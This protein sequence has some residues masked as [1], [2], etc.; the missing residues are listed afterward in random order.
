MNNLKYFISI[1]ILFLFA[2]LGITLTLSGNNYTC[3]SLLAVLFFFPVFEE[4]FFRILPL[5]LSKNKKLSP[6]FII[7]QLI[8]II[9]HFETGFLLINL[10]FSCVIYSYI[11][12]KNNL[13]RVVILHIA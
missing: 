3:V 5:I 12:E 13:L 6:V 10:I 4:L 1:I 7:F 2:V 11:L 9:L 8:W